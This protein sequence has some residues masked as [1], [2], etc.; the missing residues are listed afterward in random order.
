MKIDYKAQ[1][2]AMSD[3]LVA[4]RRDLHMYPELG[5]QE[6]RTAGRVAEHLKHLGYRVYTGIAETGV[7][8][9][10]QGSHLAVLGGPACGELVEP[11][12]GELVEPAEGQGARPGPTVMLRF[13]M[14]A[15]AVQEANEVDYASQVP[16]V[17][18]ACGHDAHV[19]I[20]MGVATLLQRHRDALAGTVKL[21]FQPAEEGMN[22]AEVMVQQ[23]VLDD[24]GPRPDAVFA[25]HMWNDLPV[26]W[27]GVA[28]GPMM[29]AA[30]RWSLTVRGRG[31]HGAAPHQTVDPIVATAQLISA[32]Q[33]IVSRN[34][35]PQKTAVVSVGTLQ[36]G[37]AFNVIPA[38]VALT[39]TIRSF[40]A[41]VREKILARFEA[42]CRG[43]ASAMDVEVDLQ[44]V[45]LT[46]ATVNDV[47]ATR[48]MREVAVE[49]L[50]ADKID[51]DCRSM[52]SEDMA[53]FM[54]EVPGCYLF[55][56]SANAARGLNYPHHNPHFDFDEAALPL[57]AAIMAETATRF[58]NRAD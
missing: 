20:G 17:M 39:G 51:D 49:V 40:D 22:G 35:D 24:Y 3:Q 46:P 54:R 1:A 9:L 48:L 6:R 13:D 31:G 25:L 26:G 33:T 34:V 15:L 43:I 23:G 2:Q 21:V 30:E 32:L 45:P 27:A 53:Y 4:W 14:D 37:T 5:F 55:L 52:G 57:G 58:L 42:L 19:A 44:M 16:G 36:G 18:H 56:G 38:Q 11:A 47:E 7:V 10:L 28:A 29:A 50:G 12:C 41:A 8:G